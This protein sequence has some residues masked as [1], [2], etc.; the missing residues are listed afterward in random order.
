[1]PN[2]TNPSIMKT[3]R[4]RTLIRHEIKNWEQ[5]LIDK[6]G[7][8]YLEYRKVW[9]DTT[10]RSNVLKFP[11]Q[12]DFETIDKC[13]LSCSFCLHNKT[14]KDSVETFNDIEIGTNKK[15][16]DSYFKKAILEGEQYG[17]PAINLGLGSELLLDNDIFN[18]IA[19][20]SL[21]GVIDIRVHTNGTLMNTVKIK[22]ILSSDISML[23][24][25]IDAVNPQTY[26]K[27][28]GGRLEV[29][30]NNLLNLISERNRL[31]LSLPIIRISFLQTETNKNEKDEFI[32]FWQ[33]K[34]EIL[35]FQNLIDYKKDSKNVGKFDCFQP[36]QRVA[37]WHQGDISLC[38][39][40]FGKKLAFN[41]IKT[42]SIYDMWHSEEATVFRKNILAGKFAEL[43]LSC[44]VGNISGADDE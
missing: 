38:C 9:H 31:K 41:N 5:P 16:D 27:L 39:T 34:V 3:K 15:L 29:V 44:K 18:K 30:V 6:F 37:I 1:M 42:T 28:R 24:V 17:L 21:H 10:K 2:T 23:C 35:D 20:A 12:L 32:K 22:E 33:D 36:W 19:F 40:F 7:D 13:N 43:C 14:F 4:L 26:K 11:L 25:S 8:K